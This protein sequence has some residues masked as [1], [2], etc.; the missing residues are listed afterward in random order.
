[1]S[2]FINKH[3]KPYLPKYVPVP[4]SVYDVITSVYN[5]SYLCR[6]V[7]IVMLHFHLHSIICGEQ[8]LTHSS[9]QIE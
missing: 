6:D 8:V 9:M 7:F 2:G 1:M 4:F 3:A 5:V